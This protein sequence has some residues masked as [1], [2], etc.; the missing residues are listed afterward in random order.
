MIFL[1]NFLSHTHAM[2]N[3]FT[4]KIQRQER[5]GKWILMLQSDSFVRPYLFLKFVFA[6]FHRGGNR[7]WAGI[8]S[9][10][11]GRVDRFPVRDNM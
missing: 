9:I 7:Y 3:I 8:I 4:N 10:R 2:N 1:F 6:W 11:S 5:R